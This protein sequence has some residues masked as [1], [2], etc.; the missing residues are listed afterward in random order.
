MSNDGIAPIN[1]PNT[2]ITFVTPII[3]ATSTDDG[4]LKIRHPKYAI[5]PIIVM[6]YVM[7]I[8]E[9]LA[10]QSKKIIYAVCKPK[11]GNIIIETIRKTNEIFGGFISGKIIKLNKPLT[12]EITPVV[13]CATYFYASGISFSVA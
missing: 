3:T 8:Q 1:G 6:V 7:S 4:I 11:T 9:T 13:I 12:T 5:T 2:G 10:G